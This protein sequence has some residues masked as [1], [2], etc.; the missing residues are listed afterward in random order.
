MILTL[1]TP[2]SRMAGPGFMGHN[3][4]CAGVEGMTRHLAG[5]LGGERHPRGVHAARTRFRKPSRLARTRVSVFAEVAARAGMSTEQML[6]GAAAGTLLKRLPTLA[7]LADDAVFVASD[8]A[9][10]MTGDD[11]QPHLR[12]TGREALAREVAA[13]RPAA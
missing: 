4:A 7:Q 3:V 1:A 13:S 6:A 12:L 10:A 8:R 5:E 11:R 2:A 9:G